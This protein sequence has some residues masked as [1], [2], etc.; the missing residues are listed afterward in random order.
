M[1][2]TEFKDKEG[3]VSLVEL[4]RFQV[5][6]LH[7]QPE[8]G[9]FKLQYGRIPARNPASVLP[10]V[11]LAGGPGDSPLAWLAHP[12]LRKAFEEL[13]ESQDVILWEQRGCGGSEP[14][15]HLGPI[16]GADLL[17]TEEAALAALTIQARTLIDGL[18]DYNPA[19]LTPWESARD[20]PPLAKH[21]GV[22]KIDILAVS[23]GTHLAMALMK[24]APKI[25]GRAIFCGFEGPD[26]TWKFAAPFSRQFG[27]DS[28]MGGAFRTFEEV[29]EWPNAAECVG[30]AVERLKENPV[31]LPDGSRVS[32]FG[33]KWMLTSWLG[34][35]SRIK[36]AKSV[37][38]GIAAGDFA[39][40]AKAASGF[41][42]SLE[43]PAAFYLNDLA[44]S[45]STERWEKIM[46]EEGSLFAPNPNFPF[47]MIREAWGQDPLPDWYREDCQWD[48]PLLVLLGDHDCFTP[49]EN[50]YDS[51]LAVEHRGE[52]VISETA[53]DQFLGHGPAMYLTQDFLAD[54]L[55]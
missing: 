51:A 33:L 17:A 29:Y 28:E 54:S 9:S 11:F 7:D 47:P 18:P 30:S 41:K 52:F 15:W 12:H 2:L 6:R 45:C 27:P 1:N 14:K 24:A 25:I 3:G 8:S 42:K 26:Q 37:C 22:E 10:L 49:V 50:Y 4:G 44:S 31:T 32:D 40:L 38:D 23:Y 13:A 21:L 34:L 48:G 16:E 55:S 39:P 46:R 53:H 43:R 36:L 35:S 19:F 5:P 20:I